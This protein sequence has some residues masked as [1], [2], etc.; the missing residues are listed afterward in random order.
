MSNELPSIQT[1]K[2]EFLKLTYVEDDTVTIQIP[3]KDGVLKNSHHIIIDVNETK[4]SLDDSSTDETIDDTT[5]YERL[6]VEQI[7]QKL[8]IQLRKLQRLVYDKH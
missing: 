4:L 3:L 8:L 1:K 2:L 6:S 5:D 7:Y